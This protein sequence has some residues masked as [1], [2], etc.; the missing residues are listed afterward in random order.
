MRRWQ[1]GETV[2]IRYHAR[3]HGVIAGGYPATC[4]EDSAER[5]VLYLPHGTTHLGYGH[6]PL[7][8]RAERVAKLAGTPRRPLPERTARTWRNSTLRFFTPGRAYQVWALWLEDS[9]E[10][11]FWYVN[12]EAPFVRTE[13]GIDTRDHTLD[14]VATPDLE[15]RW[16][17]EDE[18]TARVEHGIDS[19]E[20]A[21]AVRAEGERVVELIESRAPPFGEDWPSWRPDS[22][23]VA[24]ELPDGWADV[25][26]AEIDRS[27]GGD[28]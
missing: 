27:G 6:L 26:A 21:A 5:L 10:F 15:W 20:F 17:D 13:V 28:W 23:W 19:A 8:G 24:P 22:S 18:A 4:V 9:W 7:E 11:S 1:P 14:I 2:V 16:K 3:D 12:L 25:P